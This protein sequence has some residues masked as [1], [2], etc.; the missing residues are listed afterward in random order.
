H[1]YVY[2]FTKLA[3]PLTIA[4]NRSQQHPFWKAQGQQVNTVEDDRPFSYKDDR[5]M[6]SRQYSRF[7]HGT[8][9]N[10]SKRQGS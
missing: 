2:I 6:F 4:Q 1:M 3:M 7:Y 9:P 10:D 5:Q 8:Q